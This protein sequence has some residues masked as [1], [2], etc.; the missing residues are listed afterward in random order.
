MPLPNARNFCQAVYLLKANMFLKS[1]D[2]VFQNGY[3]E[4]LVGYQRC[5]SEYKICSFMNSLWVCIHLWIKVQL[6]MLCEGAA[7]RYTL[8]LYMMVYPS[9]C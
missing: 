4:L 2:W 9:V 3:F 1:Y 6:I 5:V 7:F 8:H